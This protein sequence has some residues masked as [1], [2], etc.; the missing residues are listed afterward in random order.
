MKVL[1]I[2]HFNDHAQTPTP[3]MVMFARFVPTVEP[4]IIHHI[5]AISTPS[6]NLIKS[7]G[8]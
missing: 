5:G 3:H 6:T 4:K 2:L 7:P 8:K 1:K